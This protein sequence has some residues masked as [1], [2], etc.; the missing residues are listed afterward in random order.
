[1]VKVG[2][3]TSV[4]AVTVCMSLLACVDSAIDLSDFINA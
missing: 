4:L 1:M 3:P 2:F